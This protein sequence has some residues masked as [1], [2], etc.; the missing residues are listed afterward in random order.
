MNTVNYTWSVTISEENL[1][2]FSIVDTTWKSVM[3]LI[4]E[5]S[6]FWDSK[7]YSIDLMPT[8]IQWS[9]SQYN[10]E[11]FATI[12]QQYIIYLQKNEQK[13]EPF[14]L[15]IERKSKVDDSFYEKVWVALKNYA[16]KIIVKSSH[17][18]MILNC[19]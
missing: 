5:A 15:T 2:V 19:D 7:S 4:S 11:N 3:D 9:E 16:D 10:V 14:R 1:T 12:I 8:L 6:L 13:D 18:T 17:K